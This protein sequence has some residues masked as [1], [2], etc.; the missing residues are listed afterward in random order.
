MN[1]SPA[2]SHLPA[3]PHVFYKNRHYYSVLEIYSLNFADNYLILSKE[4]VLTPSGH[5]PVSAGAR[6]RLDFW[7]RQFASFVSS[8]SSHAPTLF[9][10]LVA[11]LGVTVPPHDNFEA[12]L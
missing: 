3:P 1:L 12:S 7:P 2:S 8:H 6:N 5:G 4:T 9:I 10:D 11:L